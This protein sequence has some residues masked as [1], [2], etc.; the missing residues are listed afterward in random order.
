MIKYDHIKFKDNFKRFMM[1][2]GLIAIL[3]APT[4]IIFIII[5]ILLQKFKYKK[6]IPTITYAVAIA[7]LC[8]WL[9]SSGFSLSDTLSQYWHYTDNLF[10]IDQPIR[11]ILSTTY[12]LLFYHNG[13]LLNESVD[14]WIVQEQIRQQ[15]KLLP[16][17]KYNFKNRSHTLV[18]GTTR[19]GKGVFLNHE[20]KQLFENDEFFVFISAKLA[21]TDKYSSLEY[22]R[23]LAEK[24]NRK[25]YVVSMDTSVNDRCQYNPF[26]ALSSTEF[27][28][29]L[30]TLK[31]DS[32]YYSDN[33]ASWCLQI[34]DALRITKGKVSMKNIMALYDYDDYCNY[35]KYMLSED[36]ITKEQFGK[37]TS[38]T[39]KKYAEIAQN[40][41]AG[42]NLLARAGKS[43]FN[44]TPNRKKIS[45]SKAI[46]E[47]AVVFF[48]LNGNS[49]EE[50]TR[51]I[52]SGILMEIQ[53][54][55][56]RF[57]DGDVNKT[58]F[59]DE[60][61]CYISQLFKPLLSEGASAGY[62]MVISTQGPE[63]LKDKGDEKLYN[64]IINNC[65]QFCFLRM[66]T[67]EGAEAAASVIGTVCSTEN[68]R[69]AHSL[70]YTEAGSIKP[71]QVYPV[72]PN[73]IKNLNTR[74]MVYYEKR[75]DDDYVSHPVLIKWRTDDL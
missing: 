30:N 2:F 9:N 64:Q 63:D 10:L 55:T 56:R 39:I 42:L 18:T 47:N 20:L 5:D 69:R 50:A 70:E 38:S 71:I 36:I 53:H 29:V 35:L 45:L 48:D 34:V 72:H 25:L 6:Q 37:L 13:H 28:N 1:A 15:Q 4:T 7:V 16:R 73:L 62:R 14:D 40:D 8:I 57:S 74:E 54:L 67:T 68:T 58:I 43:V 65:G 24:Y 26:D 66:N 3:L 31:T 75:N 32:K 11:W 46:K 22:C 19:S 23:K 44:K 12:G 27:M 60:A 41:S 61:S 33:F 21:S 49:A 52:A 51:L 59:C 17:G